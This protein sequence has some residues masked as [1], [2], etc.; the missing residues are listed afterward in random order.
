MGIDSLV[1][2]VMIEV[3]ADTSDAKSKLKDLTGEQKKHQQALIEMLEKQNKAIDDGVKRLGLMAAA[4]GVIKGSIGLAKDGLEEFAKQGGDAKK[5]VDELTK[6]IDASF[7]KMKYAI[8]D[9]VVAMGP[10]IGAVAD[11][12][13]GLAEAAAG[14]LKV[15]A[16]LAQG[17]NPFKW[18]MD[19]RTGTGNMR[20]FYFYQ[21]QQIEEDERNRLEAI[22]TDPWSD[23]NLIKGVD[24][25][26]ADRKQ[27]AEFLAGIRAMLG[28]G[29][30]KGNGGEYGT[31]ITDPDFANVLD[32]ISPGYDQ[33]PFTKGWTAVGQLGLDP[34]ALNEQLG[35][36]TL[37]TRID[38]SKSK[39]RISYLDQMFGG[40]EQFD[41]YQRAFEALSGA[42]TSGLE[43]W[44]DGTGGAGEA[45][46]KFTA[47]MLKSLAIE[48]ATNALKYLALAASYA[49]TPGMQ[50]WVPGA[51]KSAAA[52]G[53]VAV[54]AGVGAHE[55]GG[56]GGGGGGAGAR[57]PTQTGYGGVGG[58]AQPQ[59]Q[60]NVIVYG[61][62]FAEDSPRQR[63]LKAKRVVQSAL[64]GSGLEQMG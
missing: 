41:A 52:W 17:K 13:A 35:A 4:F 10:L 36:A 9:A 23:E 26:Q 32:T 43:A 40:L 46:K 56:G 33:H 1:S 60:T 8:G 58:G 27:Q 24:K 5:Q 48:G 64:A 16:T 22:R 63:Q 54:A 39:Q 47:G 11:L 59:G 14:A 37:Q 12:T 28:K 45:I 2:K 55:L 31:T 51:L 21:S 42:V 49:A 20:D 57:S 19:G 34:R 3:K 44:I 61:D 25:A 29:K 62:S 53:A 15:I 50:F 38:E 7:S 6:G 18:D 30:G